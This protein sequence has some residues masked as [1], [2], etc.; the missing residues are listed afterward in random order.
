LDHLTGCDDCRQ[1]LARL[2]ETVDAVIQTAPE[3]EPPSGF[4]VR[5]LASFDGAV[6]ASA[7]S[8]SRS[9]WRRVALAAAVL[10]AIAA[11]AAA[12]GAVASRDGGGDQTAADRSSAALTTPGGAEVGTVRVERR[13]VTG[14]G[15]SS[16]LV[17]SVDAGARQGTYRVECDYESGGPYRAGELEVGP[18]GVTGWRTTVSV[19][20][21][22]LSRVRLVST[23]N[24][25][26]LEAEFGA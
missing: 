15:W 25:D 9:A 16:D 21:Y 11:S 2:T 3:A 17:V 4:E 8:G 13:T 10:L 22:D 7:A 6:P 26:N 23:G 24:A 18:D 19:P 12:I 1:A 5:A 14:G 20:T